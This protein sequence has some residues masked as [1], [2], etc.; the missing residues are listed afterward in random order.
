MQ[1]G[2]CIGNGI[3][4]AENREQAM[5]RALKQGRG[6]ERQGAGC[7]LAP[8]SLIKLSLNLRAVLTRDREQPKKLSPTSTLRSLWVDV[9][10]HALPPFKRYTSWKW[11]VLCRWN[12]F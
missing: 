11:A 6:R 5:A 9:V 3:L 7:C 8:L 12:P 10:R 1:D 2:L 4:T